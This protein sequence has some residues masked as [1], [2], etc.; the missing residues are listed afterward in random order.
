MYNLPRITKN[1]LLINSVLWI[2]S[3]LLGQGIYLDRL[4]G[5]YPF[6]GPF[7]IWQPLTYMFMHGSFTHLFCN[8]FAVLMF[9]PALEREWGERRY[10]LYYLVCGLGAAAVEMLVWYLTKASPYSCTIGASG[11]VFGILF[12][13]AW[14]F[15][16]VEMYLLFIPRPIR[17]RTMV[18]GYAAL[19]LLLGIGNLSGNALFSADNVAHFAHLGGMLFGWLLLLFW[20]WYDHHGHSTQNNNYNGFHY[21]RSL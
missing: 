8:M 21:Q 5:L 2:L 17:A 9:G 16:D 3:G 15:P 12:A 10:L 11:A 7:Y 14:R 1:L 4:L 6:W 19:E 13:F 20:H 18:I